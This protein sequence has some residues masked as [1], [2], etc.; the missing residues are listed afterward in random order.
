METIKR[1]VDLLD[2]IIVCL[3]K[4]PDGAI[5]ESR[6]TIELCNAAIAAKNELAALHIPE[7]KADVA[8]EGDA[9]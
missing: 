1:V 6:K 7:E 3:D 5:A 9:E 2:Y 8:H 4:R